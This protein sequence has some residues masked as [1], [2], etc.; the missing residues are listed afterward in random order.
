MLSNCLFSL[1]SVLFAL[2]SAPTLRYALARA[3]W[4]FFTFL[5]AVSI[6]FFLPRLG[7]ANPVD[8]LMARVSSA[9][10]AE[11]VREQE[12]AYLAEFGLVQR[13][14]AE[15]ATRLYAAE[16]MTR[17]TR[18]QLEGTRH[19]LT[20][21]MKIIRQHRPDRQIAVKKNQLELLAERMRGISRRQIGRRVALLEARSRVLKA[22]GTFGIGLVVGAGVALLLAPKAGSELRQDLRAKLRRDGKD[23]GGG[24]AVA[25]NGNADLGTVT[26]RSERQVT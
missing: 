10:D 4:Y 2:R 22:L 7:D 13:K 20:A 18:R 25:G 15:C 21:W 8:I 5:V 3:G 11:T 17:E 1:G 12:E 16:S 26:G 9:A 19:R 24:D 14:I 6:N 23:D